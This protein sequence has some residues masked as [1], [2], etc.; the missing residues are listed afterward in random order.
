VVIVAVQ[1]DVP[2]TLQ[3]MGG[4]V[5]TTWPLAPFPPERAVTVRVAAD[6]CAHASIPA[7][8]TTK[9]NAMPRMYPPCAPRTG[10]TEGVHSKSGTGHC[11]PVE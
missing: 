6:A 7:A 11:G 5:E 8:R 3:A 2:P 4:V 9:R 1:P 10:A